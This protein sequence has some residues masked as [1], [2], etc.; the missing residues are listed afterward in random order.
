MSLLHRPQPGRVQHEV[1]PDSAGWKHLSFSVRG[2]EPGESYSSDTGPDEV[3]IVFLGGHAQ[4]EANGQRFEVQGRASVFDGLPHALYVPPHSN[5]TITAT[6]ALEIA[7]GGAPAPVGQPVRLL[8]PQD[9][10]V[11]SRGGANVARAV[12]HVIAPPICERLFVFEVYTPSG[13]WSGFP[14]HRHDGRMG[15]SYLEETYYFRV[16]PT[17]GFGSMRVYTVDTS[18]DETMTVHDG[19]LV[20]VPEG[21]HPSNASP[22]SNIYF[23]NFL[24]GPGTD[25]TVV[26]DPRYDWLKDE[27]AGRPLRLPFKP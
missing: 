21:Y 7:I 26:N 18:L 12:T 25:Y 20:L 11:E 27:W 19:D 16:T 22:G 4:A 14:P 10:K 2:L 5:Y 23:L 6:T 9:Y 15:S 8:T 13:N 3:L 1:T 17:E 24:A